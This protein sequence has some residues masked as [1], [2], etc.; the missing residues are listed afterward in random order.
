VRAEVLTSFEVDSMG[1]PIAETLVAAP[2]SDPRA[3]AALR[4]TIDHV[5]FNPASRAGSKVRARVIRTWLFEPPPT[6]PSED[7]GI[8]C[9]RVYGRGP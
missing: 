2:G 8:D 5:R 6:C 1:T 7:D 4:R 3:V 9:A